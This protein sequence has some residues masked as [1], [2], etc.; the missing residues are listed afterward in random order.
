MRELYRNPS[1]RNKSRQIKALYIA[2]K[3][4]QYKSVLDY[5]DTAS[6]RIRILKVFKWS[7]DEKRLKLV[8]EH[9]GRG[10][11][12]MLVTVA[13][14]DF[15][16]GKGYEPARGN[17]SDFIIIDEAGFIKEDVYFNILPIVENENAKLFAISTIDW[18]TPKNWFYE[19][20]CHYEQEGDPEGYAQRV[21]IDDIDENILSAAS[22]ERMKIA[23]RGNLQRYFAELYATFPQIHSVFAT[24]SLFCLPMGE[25]IPDEVIIGYD[26]AKRSD[27]GGVVV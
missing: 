2:P 14:C 3:E 24:Q 20:L 21:T 22:K 6:E 17:G 19:L 12:S 23:L 9:L 18:N 13:T 27:Y 16:S 26:P 10:N 8:D 5:I 7:K 11:K 25:I 4:E 15:A 1:A